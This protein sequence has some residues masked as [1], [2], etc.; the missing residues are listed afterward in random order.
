MKVDKRKTAAVASKKEMENPFTGKLYHNCNYRN[1]DGFR[2]GEICVT[3]GTNKL[4]WKR[5]SKFRKRKYT[6]KDKKL[7]KKKA[8]LLIL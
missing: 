3:G 5:P 4:Y 2:K 8:L 6:I 7:C 1:G